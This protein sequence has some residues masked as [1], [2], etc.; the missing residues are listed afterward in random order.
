MI[1]SLRRTELIKHMDDMAR[2][3]EL[4]ERTE[5]Y[6]TNNY[7]ELVLKLYVMQQKQTTVAEYMNEQGYKYEGRKFI[8]GDIRSIIFHSKSDENVAVWLSELARCCYEYNRNN[9]KW[10]GFIKSI[11]EIE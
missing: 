7:E 10:G 9:V 6:T 1:Q 5:V 3:N 8:S 4:L 11:K 2:L